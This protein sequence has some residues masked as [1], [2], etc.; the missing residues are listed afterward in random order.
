[1]NTLKNSIV[2]LIIFLLVCP[3][4]YAQ[5]SIQGNIENWSNGEVPLI[6]KDYMS[7]EQSTMG[8]ISSNGK[9]TIP[10]DVNFLINLK[11]AANKANEDAPKG[12]K[13]NF[14]TVESVFG[15]SDQDITYENATVILSG[16]PDL[17]A[18]RKDGTAT[19]G[20]LYCANNLEIS[21]WLHNY[22][23][24]N[25]AKGYY[26]RWFF[27]E[28]H[29]SAKGTCNMPTYTGNGDENYMDTTI[30]DLDL[31]KGWNIIKYAIIE[32]FTSQTGKIAPSKTEITRIDDVPED[33]QWLLL[34]N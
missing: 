24:G 21:T 12:R 8:N 33:A 3:V 15:C 28:D 16:L 29:A 22:G 19:Y 27:V 14:N 1:M 9:M 32:T 34:S 31:Q 17:E 26:L 2:T 20:Y 4:F 18:L 5:N 30:Y 11:E 23:Q 7:K 13:I 10:L 6:F 25:I